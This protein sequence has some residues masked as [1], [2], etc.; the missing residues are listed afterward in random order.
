MDALARLSRGIAHDLNNLLQPV[1]G[2]AEVLRQDL[3]DG[4][5]EQQEADDLVLSIRQAADLVHRMRDA[6][7]GGGDRTE[8]VDLAE[9]A[10]L[11]VRTARQGSS[12]DITVH[13]DY[14]SNAVVQGDPSALHQ[15]LMNLLL[16]AGQA[17]PEGGELDVGIALEEGTVVLTVADTGVGMDTRTMDRAFE[18]FFTHGKAR[19]TGLGL[20]T[21]Y[22][23][24]QSMDGEIEVDSSPGQ[25]ARFTV[26]FVAAEREQDRPPVSEHGLDIVL[27]D[28]QPISRRA[29]RRVLEHLGHAVRVAST[30]AEALATLEERLPDVL[31][32]EADLLDSDPVGDIS[33][34]HPALR[35]IVYAAIHDVAITR[36]ASRLGASE[37]L[38]KPI[39]VEQWG[40]AI[41]G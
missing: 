25:G 21:V 6:I 7:R 40:R 11:C 18:P 8:P 32:M 9:V 16:N 2:Y 4:S 33:R 35:V 15:I 1:L 3:P 31:V 36:R 10:S 38:V 41:G 19:G 34:C 12:A 23:I 20:A 27:A 14:A 28:P 24:V 30:A 17:M 13:E 37:V 5:P 29:T 26:R 22:S 39:P